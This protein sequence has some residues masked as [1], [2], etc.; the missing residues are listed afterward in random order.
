MTTGGINPTRQATLPLLIMDAA[1]RQFVAFN[2]V[3]DTGFN[4]DVQLPSLNIARLNLP[5]SGTAATELADGRVVES[6]AYDATVL[7][8]GGRRIVKVIDGED[9]IPLIGSNLL[10]GSSMTIDWQFGGRVTVAPI[11]EPK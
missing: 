6:Q 11:P 7:W 1:S 5:L 10:W 8:Q 9:G 2:L 4:G 3:I